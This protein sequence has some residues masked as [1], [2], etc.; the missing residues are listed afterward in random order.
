MRTAK[1]NEVDGS[2]VDNGWALSGFF[3]LL[4]IS[5]NIE[6]PSCVVF[7]IGD[8]L[9]QLHIQR[10]FPLANN[11]LFARWLKKNSWKSMLAISK[12][13]LSFVHALVYVCTWIAK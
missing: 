1:E 2:G 5:F 3:L 9:L 7:I 4:F 12:L 11:I 8:I 13:Y 10:K 6:I